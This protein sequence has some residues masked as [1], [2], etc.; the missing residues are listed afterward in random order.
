MR[1]A[2]SESMTAPKVTKMIRVT[3]EAHEALVLATKGK[4]TFSETILR[5]AKETS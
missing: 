2:Y 3:E 4:E 1:L 5:L